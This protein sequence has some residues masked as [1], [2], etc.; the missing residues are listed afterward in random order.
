[1]RH[2]TF[3][4]YGGKEEQHNIQEVIYLGKKGKRQP[5]ESWVTTILKIWM[6]E[7]SYILD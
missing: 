5:R 1:M 7:L 6:Q 3:Q 4:E 2:T